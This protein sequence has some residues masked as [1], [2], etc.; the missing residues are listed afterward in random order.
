M[1]AAVRSELESDDALR[2]ATAL[3][4]VLCHAQGLQKLLMSRCYETRQDAMSWKAHRMQVDVILC[5][6]TCALSLHAASWRLRV[7]P[8]S[9]L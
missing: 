4:Q 7:R 1:A 9:L 2:Q 8:P 5:G 3:L 6:L